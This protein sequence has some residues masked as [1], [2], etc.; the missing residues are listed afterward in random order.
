MT[1]RAAHLLVIEDDPHTCDLLK[2][3]FPNSGCA[4][5]TAPTEEA[6]IESLARQA[7]EM[8]IADL[9]PAA[10]RRLDLLAR[11][12]SDWPDIPVVVVSA[13]RS[14]SFAVEAIRLGASEYITKPLCLEDLTLRVN[15]CMERNRSQKH[16]GAELHEN[17]RRFDLSEIV[18]RSKPMQKVLEVIKRIACRRDTYALIVGS[19]GTGKELVAQAIHKNS[20]RR[21]APFVP[22]HCS[23]I[24][25]S[26]FESELFG[27]EKGAFTDAE[28][29]RAGL[30][31]NA[32]GGTVFLDEIDALSLQMQVKLLRVLQERAIR[33]VG[34]R[35]D[36]PL[37]VRVL[38]ASN[39]NLKAAVRAGEFRQDLYYRLNSVRVDIPD[40]KDRREDIPLLVAHF[41]REFARQQDEP[42]R[43]FT[44]DALRLLL[45]YDWPG[46]VRELQ[47][48]VH[49]GLTLG[50][51]AL[52]VPEDLPAG[53]RSS[54]RD[55]L[56]EAVIDKLSLAEV[57]RRY[58]FNV[59]RETD[60]CTGKA[61][62]VLGMDRRTL[63]QR[64]RAYRWKGQIPPSLDQARISNRA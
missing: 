46:N 3:C 32:S 52:L 53:I 57:Q 55:L 64:L 62:K 38:S 4:I 63:Y 30:F 54:K 33:R 6:A 17:T 29:G 21:Q 61:A 24:P 19:T 8:V 12:R 37:D 26:L 42:V 43:C 18:G 51:S 44:A 36:V 27:H 9:H 23:A 48:A 50:G 39:R 5:F 41:L 28:R 45:T 31:E 20:S 15:Q 35:K 16:P 60:F 13:C 1:G 25:E 40:L 59:L 10:N 34:G 58:I 22:I 14:V 47:N 11:I 7:F 49:H 2:K 56:A